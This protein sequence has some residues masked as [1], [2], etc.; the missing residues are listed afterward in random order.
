MRSNVIAHSRKP[1]GFHLTR[2]L[3]FGVYRPS[4]EVL[5]PAFAHRAIALEGQSVRIEAR[6]TARAAR[7]F[8]ML[9]EHVPQRQFQRRL[10]AR[11]LR[12]HGR[13]RGNLLP[14]H[15]SDHPISTLYRAGS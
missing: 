14:E 10:V 11:Q 12:Y 7:I 3:G 15:P 1:D 6:M 13:G 9:G 8:T 5:G 4:R 2:E